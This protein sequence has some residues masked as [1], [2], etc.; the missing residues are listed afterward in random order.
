MKEEIDVKHFICHQ[1]RLN[2]ILIAPSISFKLDTDSM[3]MGNH[4]IS[5]D[6]ALKNSKNSQ[7]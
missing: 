1:Y 2:W 4:P 5:G 7:Y 3:V 6:Y